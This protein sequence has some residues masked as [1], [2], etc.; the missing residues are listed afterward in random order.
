MASFWWIFIS[1]LIIFKKLFFYCF[2]I[3]KRNHIM[4]LKLIQSHS[5]CI[6]VSKRF[7]SPKNN[8]SFSNL[9]TCQRGLI[10][11]AIGF[12]AGLPLSG[13]IPNFREFWL[14]RGMKCDRGKSWEF[15]VFSFFMEKW[16][17]TKKVWRK[18]R[19]PAMRGIPRKLFKFLSRVADD[20][21]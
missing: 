15:W 7:A 11:R 9:Q 5:Y 8:Q 13:N 17:K 21:K 19:N 20:K 16:R 2:F 18:R 4:S 3:A 12:D 6:I 14:W 1:W 10:G